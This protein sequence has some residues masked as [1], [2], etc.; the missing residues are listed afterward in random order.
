MLR[1]RWKEMD[2]SLSKVAWRSTEGLLVGILASLIVSAVLLGAPSSPFTSSNIQVTDHQ[3]IDEQYQ[4]VLINTGNQPAKGVT[5]TIQAM[6]IDYQEHQRIDYIASGQSYTIPFQPQPILQNTTSNQTEISAVDR[7]NAIQLC[8]S[9]DKTSQ[10]RLYRASIPAA[11]PFQQA[12]RD[13]LEY[14]EGK[15][16]F[17]NT[18]A[19]EIQETEYVQKKAS[20]T[21]YR[22]TVRNKQNNLTYDIDSFTYPEST[23]NATNKSKEDTNHPEEVLITR[24]QFGECSINGKSLRSALQRNEGGVES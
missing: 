1:D 21:D 4:T 8:K 17:N 11:N 10:L 16:F 18:S 5:I 22:V 2:V 14:K 7:Q 19:V 12:T 15:I 3:T 24:N 20:P 9:L 23:R 13:N 6:N